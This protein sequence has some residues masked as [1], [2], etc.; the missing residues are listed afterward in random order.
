MITR[1]DESAL[2]HSTVPCRAFELE[3]ARGTKVIVRHGRE[4]DRTGKSGPKSKGTCSSR[5]SS[6]L[7]SLHCSSSPL[8]HLSRVSSPSRL[9]SSLSFISTCNGKVKLHTPSH[10]SPL[11]LVQVYFIPGLSSPLPLSRRPYMRSVVTHSLIQ[12][13]R[14]TPYSSSSSRSSQSLLVCVT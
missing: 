13:T 9:S 3:R 1:V 6:W 2:F 14:V 8:S 11:Y 4:R 7:S 10:I 5:H 12:T